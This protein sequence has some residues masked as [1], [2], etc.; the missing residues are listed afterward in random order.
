MNIPVPYGIITA[1]PNNDTCRNEF[2]NLYC[3]ICLFKTFKLAIQTG[4]CYWC[5]WSTCK[6]AKFRNYSVGGR[7]RSTKI[8]SRVYFP[9]FQASAAMFMRSALFWDITR[10]R[11]VIVYRRFGKQLHTMPRNIPEERRSQSIFYLYAAANLR[12]AVYHLN[13]GHLAYS[14]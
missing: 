4:R 1:I 10:R 14:S 8:C 9:W 2:P 3:N 12:I 5:W 13:C 11:V 6:W 7:V